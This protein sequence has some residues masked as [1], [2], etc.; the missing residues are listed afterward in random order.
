MKFYDFACHNRSL[1]VWPLF[2]LVLVFG[3]HKPPQSSGEATEQADNER[4]ATTEATPIHTSMKLFDGG[5]ESIYHSFRIPSIIKT[6]N[7]TLVAFAEGRRWS[8]SDYGDINVVFKRS[9]NNGSTWSALGEVAASG[10]GTWGNPTAVYDPNLG[11]NGRLWLFMC[12][13]DGAIDEWADFD[14]WGDRKVYTSYSDDHGATW[15]T[16]LDRTSTLVPPTYKWDAVGPGNGIIT[17]YNH[18]GRLIVPALGRNIYSDDHGVTWQYQLIPGTTDESTIVEL[19][20]GR[21]MRNDRPNTTTWN[22]T[23]KRRKS[24]GTIEGGF[25]AF[26]PDNALTDPKCEGSMIRYNTDDPARIYF[27]NPNDIDQRCNMTVRISYDE[28][29]TWARSRPIFDWNTCD[30]AS[31]TVAKGGYSGMAKTADYC[32][33]AL[34]EINEDVHS[35]STSNKSIEFH[36]FNLPWILNGNTEP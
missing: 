1:R 2:L 13:N 29:Q 30:Y 25:G 7:G 15:S 31:I 26:A 12:W 27:L 11:T 5:N 33:G 17:T 22:T 16:P 4:T 32:V 28:G 9:L 6:K 34:I 10:S 18:P 14:S 21:L 3:C 19:M 8:P 20:D 23:K 36:K 35:S 24:F